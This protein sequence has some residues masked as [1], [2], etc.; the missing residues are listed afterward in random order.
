MA[1]L[2]RLVAGVAHELNN[3]I[4]FVYGNMHALQRYT[5]RLSLYFDAINEG[6]SRESL[7][8]MREALRLD[9]LIRDLNSLVD[10]TMEGADRVKEIVNDLRQFSS[11]Q[12]SEK[13][14]SISPTLFARPCIG[15][16]RKV[17]TQLRYVKRYRMG[18]LHLDT[19]V[20]SIRLWSIL[21]RMPSMR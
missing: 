7:K 18:Y 15:S 4:S 11:T 3:P 9:K 1:S 16:L 10:G 20:R 13:N 6:Q 14:A 8:A 21:F 17:N 19:P 2:G 12:E 5:A